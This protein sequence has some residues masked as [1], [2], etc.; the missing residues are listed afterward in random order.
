MYV[1]ALA[2]I[3]SRYAPS[4][5]L[6]FDSVHVFKV[7]QLIESK[8]HVSRNILCKEL[9]LGEGSVKTLVKQLKTQGIIE[10]T[11][12]GTTT[13]SKGKRISEQLLSAIPAEMSLS[14]CSIALGKFN[15]AV[16]LKQ[17]GFALKSGIEQR[18]AAIRMGAI[19]A[20]SLLFKRNRFVMPGTNY[21]ALTKESNTARLL[22]ERL[23][24]EDGD[25]IVIGSDMEDESR[26]E[27]A[28]KN[29]ALTT[30]MAHERHHLM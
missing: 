15:Y 10:S 1:K 8:G 3:A 20:T 7:L 26:A 25:A 19:G 24:P 12:A 28:A 21:D 14:K 13:T 11:R 18:D 17:Y 16:L 30:I 22:L 27:L 9:S 6:S 29:A 5:I 23:K 4:R 2:K